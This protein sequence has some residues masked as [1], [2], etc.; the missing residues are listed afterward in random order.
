M[1]A[2]ISTVEHQVIPASVG[3]VGMKLAPISFAAIIELWADEKEVPR[4][5]KQAAVTLFDR[6]AKH[7]GHDEAGRV[8]SGDL[9]SFKE[10]LVQAV[11]RGDLDSTTVQNR[12]QMLKSIFRWA[13]KNRK[14]DSN[15]AVDLAY[16]GKVDP[17]AVRQDFTPADMRL[18]LTE[19][20]KAANPVIRIS[21]SPSCRLLSL[22]TPARR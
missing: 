10:T 2:K 15:P 3:Q 21:T 7:L 12:I 8:T 19:C 6:L 11:K 1:L 17:R 18:I 13:E 22:S 16:V 5:R 4:K 14:I 9:V 20:R